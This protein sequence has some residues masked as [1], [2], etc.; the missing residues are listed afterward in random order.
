MSTELLLL[1]HAKSDWHTG[2]QTDHA[3][4][5]NERGRQA[6]P[7]MGRFMHRNDLI[8]DRILCSTAVRTRETCAGLQTMW[9]HTVPTDYVDAIYEARLEALLDTIAPC[10]RAGT[11][12]LVVG[13]NPGMEKLLHHLVPSG[14]HPA[15]AQ[16]YP[17]CTLA[18]IALPE[19]SLAAGRGELLRLEFV[20]RLKTSV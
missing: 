4:P 17:T 14:A 2:A 12:L 1:R 7:K 11:R 6:A 10:L 20:K 8:P 3:R 9:P 16:G 18:Q 13:H 15:M 19:A 5:L